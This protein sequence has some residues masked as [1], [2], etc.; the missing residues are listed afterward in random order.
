MIVSPT[1]LQPTAEEIIGQL[2]R[3]APYFHHFQIDIQ[4]GQYTPNKT[5]TLEELTDY[6]RINNIHYPGQSF[7]IDIMTTHT[8]KDLAALSALSNYLPVVSAFVH[9]SEIENYLLLQKKFTQIE[10]GLSLNPDDSVKSLS[11]KY[12]LDNIPI[13]QI[14]TINSGPQGQS[15][16]YECINKVDQLRQLNYR[17]KIYVDGGLNEKTIPLLHN[18]KN[19]PDV[20]YVGSYFKTATDIPKAIS[21]L[22]PYLE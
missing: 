11:H 12:S 14:M 21:L 9:D 8:I 1:I 19:K 15:F 17:N 13:I 3:L 18:L 22:Q 4:D 6:C 7:N 10:L 2:K 5:A 16:I 20:L